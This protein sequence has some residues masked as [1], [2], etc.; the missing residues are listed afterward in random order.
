MS[1]ALATNNDAR[2]QDDK[3]T[4]MLDAIGSKWSKF[5]KQELSDLK[6]NDELVTQVVAKYGVEK[7]A[8]QH[9]VD[10]LMNGHNLT[11]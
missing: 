1:N 7:I 5:S 6:T 3:R 8:A 4:E 2:L 9:D 11:A 10:A